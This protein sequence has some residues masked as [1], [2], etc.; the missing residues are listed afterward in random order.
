MGQEI[1]VVGTACRVA[2]AEGPDALWELVRSGTDATG[3]APTHRWP[4]ATTPPRGGYLDRVDLFD[5]GF[6][7][8]S[9]REAAAMDPQQRMALELGWHAV[10]SAGIRV[11][12]LEVAGPAAVFLGV[13]WDDYAGLTHDRSAVT[14]HSIG[15]LRRGV[16]A[17]R[18]SHALG[19]HGPSLTVDTAQSSSL[20]A[21]HLACAALRSG[22]AAV[23]LAGGVNVMIDSSVA[24][25]GE[26]AALSPS[27]RC[28]TFDATADGF[29]RGEGGGIV[30][31]KTLERARTDGDRV[32]CVLLGS[33]TNNDGGAESLATP[34][35]PAQRDVVRAAY[36]AAGVRPA[37]VGYV[38]LHG[39]G[40]RVGDAT[41]A[42][43][44]GAVFGAESE[45]AGALPVGSVKTNIG[46]LESAAGVLGLIKAALCVERGELV[47]SLHFTAPPPELPLDELGL[48][49]QTGTAAWAGTGRRIA[50]VSSFGMG[51][52]NCHVVVAAAEPLPEA[53]EVADT[54]GPWPVVLSGRSAEG[55]RAHAAALR[56]DLREP[57]RVAD[58]A[59][60]YATTRTALPYRAAVVAAD[61]TELDAALAALAA[62]ASRVEQAATGPSAFLFAG[63]GG[64]RPGMGLAL[65]AAFPDV[66]AVL[67]A[68]TD[69]LH[70]HRDVPL[71]D[72]LRAEP[73]T[74]TAALLGTAA[75]AQPA[76]FALQLA[77]RRPRQAHRHPPR[78]RHDAR[79]PRRRLRGRPAAGRPRGRGRHR[80][81]QRAPLVRRL[82]VRRRRRRRGGRLP[83]RRVARAPPRGDARVPLPARRRDHRRLRRR[84]RRPAVR[85][86]D[87]AARVRDARPARRARRAR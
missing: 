81:D 75:Y 7:G 32:L 52:A 6:F 64:A 56:A 20:V 11:G 53:S 41:E 57:Y 31:L 26:F 74:P 79:R 50:G 12:D 27:G 1:A 68:V 45:R 8:I 72:V 37:D 80:G 38:E 40:T 65:A 14:R 25:A 2:G 55:V 33:A 22:E 4:G 10:E 54:G 9:P 13:M 49:V 58:L 42:A 23:A 48:R 29:A 19:V 70:P 28:A 82:G 24:E 87:A 35:L 84:R 78:R 21:V 60:S 44:L 15:G 73:G 18:L 76:L 43:A 67:D 17:N 62:P 69:A 46:H 30:V 77:R 66:T 3:P 59:W 5:A 63:Q 34:S 47:P 85:A 36:A 86:R 39:T 61:P 71:L 51:G 83:R 16:L